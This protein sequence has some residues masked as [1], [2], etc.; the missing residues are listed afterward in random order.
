MLLPA[1]LFAGGIVLVACDLFARTLFRVLHTDAAGGRTTSW[2][3]RCFWCCCGE[4]S[5]GE[6]NGPPG[7]ASIDWLGGRAQLLVH[8]AAMG[9]RDYAHLAPR[10]R[11][12]VDD[13]VAARAM[14]TEPLELAQ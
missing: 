12:L 2:E 10:R 1:S 9:D 6:R 14:A 4:A 8:V 7:R 3:G 13:S 11:E 5:V